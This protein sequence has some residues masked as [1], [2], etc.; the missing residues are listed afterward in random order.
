MESTVCKARE[1]RHPAKRR[2]DGAPSIEILVDAGGVGHQPITQPITESPGYRSESK[3]ATPEMAILSWL[4]LKRIASYAVSVF[5]CNSKTKLLAQ[6]SLEEPAADSWLPLFGYLQTIVSSRYLL[7]NS[8]V[9][10]IREVMRLSSAKL[11]ALSYLAV[12]FFVLALVSSGAGQQNPTTP[13]AGASPAGPSS[14][15]FLPLL[16]DYVPCLLGSPELYFL[17]TGQPDPNESIV[18]SLTSAAAGSSVP[19]QRVLYAAIENVEKMPLTGLSAAQTQQVVTTVLQEAIKAEN[20]KGITLTGDELKASENVAIAAVAQSQSN[21]PSQSP[22]PK[23]IG[24]SMSLMPWSEAYK[25]FGREVADEYLAVQVDVRNMDQNHEFL[26]HDAEFAVDAYGGRLDRFQVGHEKQ[27]VR[28]VSVWGENYGRHAVGV[29]IVE[30]V[31]IIMGAVVGLPQPNI[32]N[33]TYATGAYQAGFIPFFNKLFPNLSTNNLNNLNDFGFSAT[34][35]SRIVVPKG[36]S[37]PFVLFVPI[38]PL[39]QACWLQKGYDFWKDTAF[40]SYCSRLCGDGKCA[41][42]SPSW[43]THESTYT[44]FVTIKYK[45]WTPIQLEA[46][47]KHSF[48]AVAGNFFQELTGTL[49]LNSVNCGATDSSNSIEIAPLGNGGL[50]CALGGT[51]LDSMKTLRMRPPNNTDDANKIDAPVTP[52][53]D[54]STATAS[55]APADV[56]RITVQSYNLFWVD[57][58][59]K[60]TDLKQSLSFLPPPALN[61]VPPTDIATFKKTP[62]LNMS[63]KYLQQVNQVELEDTSNNNNVVA[64]ATALHNAADNTTLAVTFRTDVANQLKDSVGYKI[65]F[66]LNDAN[67]SQ[68]DSGQSITFAKATQ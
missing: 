49:T 35:N 36:G 2:R 50:N 38:E 23:G 6:F 65:V 18:R 42:G 3:P 60:E 1:N 53:S 67:S 66:V 21:L 52:S 20:A 15:D 13:G 61:L 46:L 8:L 17:R 12:P 56:K 16:Q 68:Y 11:S 62:T 55:F 59:N 28:G 40:I 5:E 24:C 29:H 47:K 4:R 30:G 43:R 33:L 26:L 64:K 39:M 44:N 31:G 58:S 19:M 10:G 63:G 32:Q 7:L 54:G 48:V 45:H 41:Q 14:T 51:A 27:V 25:V 57:S 34:A 9:L 22:R 37:V